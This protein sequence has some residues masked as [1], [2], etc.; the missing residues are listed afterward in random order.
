MWVVAALVVDLSSQG[1]TIYARYDG[2]L[3]FGRLEQPSLEESH[4]NGKY[5]TSRLSHE[6]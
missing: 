3:Q 1:S 5:P 2:H 4:K 6:Q